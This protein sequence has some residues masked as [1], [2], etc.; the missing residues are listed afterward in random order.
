MWRV[1]R[2]GSVVASCLWLNHV[3]AAQSFDRALY[4]GGTS[5]Y[6][7]ATFH[8][9]DRFA[10]LDLQSNLLSRVAK[11]AV[12]AADSIVFRDMDSTQVNG[13][14]GYEARLLFDFTPA[15]ATPA[16]LLASILSQNPESVLPTS[17][18]GQYSVAHAMVLQCPTPCGA[19]GLRA[20][21]VAAGSGSVSCTC[22]CDPGWMTDVNQPFESFEYCSIATSTMAPTS[23]TVPTTSTTTPNTSTNTTSDNNSIDWRPPLPIYPPPPPASKTTKKKVPLFKWIIIGVSILVIA[24]LVFVLCRT[25]CCGLWS[26]CCGGGCCPSASPSYKY[27]VAPQRIH[28]H[29]MHHPQSQHPY[30]ASPVMHHPYP[31]QYFAPPPPESYQTP[32]PPPQPAMAP[33]GHG[34]QPPHD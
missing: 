8:G 6:L 7:K 25:R 13:P 9:L 30:T 27:P 3:V 31:I 5:A 24:I 12:G 28:V 21:E 4:D 20:P 26:I 29:A 17:V 32:P 15:D 23:P 10:F 22:Q 34:F 1:F 18:F 16:S 2:A 14:L 33:L 19:H 11:A